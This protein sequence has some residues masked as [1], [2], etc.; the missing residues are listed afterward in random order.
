MF[1]ALGAKIK[2]EGGYVDATAKKLVGASMFLGGS[3]RPDGSGHGECND[4]G[5]FG[6]TA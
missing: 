6:G 1:E 4:D 3:R 2:I 5:G